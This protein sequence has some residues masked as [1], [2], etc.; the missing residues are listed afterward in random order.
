MS[1]CAPAKL[2]GTPGEVF[3]AF[4]KLGCTSFGG[5]IAHL[6]YF[7]DEL[8]ERRRWLDDRTYGELVGLCQFLPGP[9]SSQ[10][11]FAI[12]LMRA[13]PLGGLAAW[14][15]FTMPSALLMFGFALVAADLSGPVA[16]SAIHGLKIAA[17]AVVAQALFG[18][19]RALTP[20]VQRMA[21]AAV[22]TTATLVIA[23][24]A[25]QI[26]LITLGALFGLIFCPVRETR[27][28]KAFGWAPC[29]RAGL[30]C[31]GFFAAFLLL[32]PLVAALLVPF[33]LADIFYR[34]GALVFGGGHVVLP[35]LRAGLVPEWMN[36]AQFLAGYGAAQ[37]VPGPLFTL[38]AYL[39]ACTTPGAPL[40]GAA[41]ALVMIFLPGLLLIAGA[42]PFRFAISRNG[43]AR[44]AIAGVNATV[45]G[46]LA[47]AL[48]DPLWTAGI[49]S[50]ADAV[51]AA[52]GL[53]LLVW[54]RCPPL[55]VVLG[56]VAAAIALQALRGR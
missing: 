55:L 40:A 26:A 11:G 2:V 48:Y 45:V 29:R 15:G 12:G 20:D 39:G 7:R 43:R 25:A 22:A 6:G 42:L 35:L 33:A 56:S 10:V 54:L 27:P 52:G 21:M 44:A 32:L 49:A 41:L 28:Q 37:A 13:G 5:P 50:R 9:A 18:M 51:I 19:A 8:V 24:P 1:T 34:A 3:G 46:I 23:V 14:T 38:A 53:G 47:A 4:L 31:L 16:D 36:D 17:V 30:V